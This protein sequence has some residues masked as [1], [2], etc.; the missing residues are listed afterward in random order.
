M[1]DFFCRVCGNAFPPDEANREFAEADCPKCNVVVK[2]LKMGRASSARYFRADGE[3]EAEAGDQVS[4]DNGG[5][6]PVERK[7]PPVAPG[8]R[9]GGGPDSGNGGSGEPPRGPEGQEKEETCEG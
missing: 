8:E 4:G 1:G 9:Q 7:P 2:R 5:D 3:G 6:E